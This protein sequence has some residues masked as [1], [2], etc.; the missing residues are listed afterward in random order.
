M[1]GERERSERGERERSERGERGERGEREGRERGGRG[2]EREIIIHV[3]YLIYPKW[4]ETCCCQT[5]P[6]LPKTN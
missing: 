3:L 4:K 1:R 5:D 2:G 6:D